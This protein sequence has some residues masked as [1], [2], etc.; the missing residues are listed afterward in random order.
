MDVETPDRTTAP[1][2]TRLRRYDDLPGPRGLPVVGNA[3]QID[4]RAFHLQLRALVPRVRAVLQAAHRAPAR[5]G[6][7]RPRARGARCCATG[8]RAFA[9]P[10]GWKTIWTEMG[11]QPGLFGVNGEVWKRQRR[12]VMAGFDPAHVKRYLPVAAAGGRSAWPGA[13]RRPRGRAR[14]ST[15]RPT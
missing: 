5:A 9:A 11:L 6:G 12:M 15:C 1:A 14:R 3:L 2:T 13:G 8:P 4:S 10:R 7:R